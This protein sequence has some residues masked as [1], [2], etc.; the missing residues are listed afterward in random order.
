MTKWT[1]KDLEIFIQHFAQFDITYLEFFK[2]KED[3]H[4]TGSPAKQYFET[5]FCK[6][7]TYRCRAQ[8]KK[9]QGLLLDLENTFSNK[10]TENAT[11]A[12]CF[13]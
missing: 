12:K 9:Q 5:A 10:I 3:R 13:I 4:E 7:V 11:R 6:N 8:V 2:E 1:L